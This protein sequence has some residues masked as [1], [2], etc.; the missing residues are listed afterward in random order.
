[1]DAD[2][3]IVGAGAAGL[4]AAG[5]AAAL[6]RRVLVLEKTPRAGSKVLASGGTRCNLT[7]T[8]GADAAARLFGPAERFLQPSLRALTPQAIRATFHDLGVPTVEEPALEKVF[9]ASQRAIDVRDALV[10]R[11]TRAG[12]RLRF[13][14]R[15]LGVEAEGGGW[16]VTLGD[17]VVRC[18]RLLL[19]PGGASYAATGTTGD[20]YRWLRDLDLEVV[21]AVPALVPLTSAA[22]WVT[23]LAGVSIQE[24]EAR[25]LDP[26]GRIVQ[27]RARPVLF[28][29]HGLSG[30]GAMD[31]SSHV[32][33]A[34]QRGPTAG[35][36]VALD[37]LPSRPQEAVRAALEAASR[38]PGG[39][40]LARL[41]DEPPIGPVALPA[42]LVAAAC[43]QAGITDTN[44]A[45]NQ[46]D[47]GA[48]N[49]LVD[50]LK[51]LRVP[52]D[53]TLGW[54]KAEVTAG[55]LALGEVERGTMAV[56][57]HPGLYA[58]GEILDLTGPIGGLNFTAAFATAD[59]A[60]R[61]AAK[62]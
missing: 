53:G 19:C 34:A 26:D 17:G 23:E 57:R 4:W 3:V 58:F 61:A 25:L 28:T 15:V 1:M 7:T 13:Q 56:R 30:P 33:R 49:R 43:A 12:A 8:L 39:P 5:T 14:A 10:Q 20:G 60:A 50:A 36:H 35:W 59:L 55:G 46:V 22:G 41:L 32:A 47:R 31:L 54:D 18:G 16:T 2:I 40:R 38:A 44:P 29:H 21:P 27:R 62:G 37:L 45:L 48:R 52:V 24:V 11:A 42:R 6:G 51:G 9:P